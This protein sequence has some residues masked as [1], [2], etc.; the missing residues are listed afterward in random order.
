MVGWPDA[1]LSDVNIAR[2][3]LATKHSYYSISPDI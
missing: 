1:L 2:Q 3:L